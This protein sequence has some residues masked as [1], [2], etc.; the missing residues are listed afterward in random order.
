MDS[1]PAEHFGTND[2]QSPTPSP[3]IG[4]SRVR[5]LEKRRT[6]TCQFADRIAQLSIQH[7]RQHV[8][9]S[10]EPTCLATIVA[11]RQK[12][13]HRASVESTRRDKASQ[14]SEEKIKSTVEDELFVVSMGVGTKFLSQETLHLERQTVT[15]V[16]ETQSLKAAP[17]VYGERVRDCHVR[18][19]SSCIIA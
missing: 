19:F 1:R 18:V 14:V 17:T 8:P 15:G 2:G 10:N 12:A 9:A 11:F 5:Y 3:N 6:S 4:T 13:S 7:Y 16:E